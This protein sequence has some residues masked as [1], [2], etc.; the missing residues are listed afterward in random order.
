MNCTSHHDSPIDWIDGG[1]LPFHSIRSIR[2][3]SLGKIGEHEL[4]VAIAKDAIKLMPTRPEAYQNCA[5]SMAELAMTAEVHE[6]LSL[7][8][9]AEICSSAI[10][11]WLTVC[12]AQM[13][14]VDDGAS[15]YQLMSM[16]DFVAG[17][18]RE[19]IKALDTCLERD[20][21]RHVCLSYRARSRHALYQLKQATSDYRMLAR[22]PFERER[23]RE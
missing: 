3:E 5:I 21:E 9:G 23:E 22:T 14:A 13:A 6:I 2:F 7:V 1:L 20:R 12:V 15:R 11:A 16:V 17:R 8:R 4:A 19:A 18:Y 10:A